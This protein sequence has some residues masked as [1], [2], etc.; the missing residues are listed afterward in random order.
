[1]PSIRG[2]A[3]ALALA[4]ALTGCGG[5][6]ED[7]QYLGGAWTATLAPTPAWSA[8]D[9]DGTGTAKVTSDDGTAVQLTVTGLAPATEYMSHVHD[10][11]CDQDPPGGG[12]WLADP[13][14]EDAA[15]NIIEL[16]FTTSETGTGEA[17]V[18]SDLVLDD[19]AKSVVVHAPAEATEAEGLDSDRVLCGDLAAD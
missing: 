2:T 1:M 8:A 19:R 10:A 5:D 9:P 6:A 4:A 16:H 3:A 14:G 17:T 7:P 15:G 13:S 11:E 18:S 12:H